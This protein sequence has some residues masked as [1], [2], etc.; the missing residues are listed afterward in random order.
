M[1]EAVALSQTVKP[2][3][4]APLGRDDR[5]ASPDGKQ[6]AADAPA[7]LPKAPATVQD[8]PVAR[9]AATGH[10]RASPATATGAPAEAAAGALAVGS[11]EQISP[12]ALVIAE[13]DAELRGTGLA[14][15][16]AGFSTASLDAALQQILQGADHFAHTLTHNPSFL[17]WLLAAMAGGVGL[18]LYRRRQ[19]AL[20]PLLAAASLT[21]DSTLS[22]VP[23]MPGSF[24]DEDV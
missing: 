21:A 3:S 1:S 8:T 12:T 20:R 4:A 13:S 5:L 16:D 9:A 2:D 19:T 24:S 7:K 11:A 18:E 15:G 22:W 10:E 17:P 23:G 14:A 6:A